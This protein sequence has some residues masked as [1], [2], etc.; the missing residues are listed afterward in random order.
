MHARV[1]RPGSVPHALTLCCG[2]RPLGDAHLSTVGFLL[3]LVLAVLAFRFWRE[4][5]LRCLKRMYQLNIWVVYAGGLLVACF[6]AGAE[7][8]LPVDA[9]TA[10]GRFG[11]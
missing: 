9:G 11:W 2:R 10:A 8:G 4:R 7:F 1:T 3:L 5:C 6:W